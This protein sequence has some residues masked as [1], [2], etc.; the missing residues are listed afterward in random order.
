MILT[1]IAA[2]YIFIFVETVS[3]QVLHSVLTAELTQIFEVGS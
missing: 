3:N 2:P 1:S